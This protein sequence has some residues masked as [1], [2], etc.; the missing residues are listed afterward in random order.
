MMETMLLVDK[1]IDQIA[2]IADQR[3]VRFGFVGTRIPFG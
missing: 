3:K 2:V 1:Y